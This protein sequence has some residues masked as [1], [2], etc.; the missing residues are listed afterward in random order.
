MIFSFILR[1]FVLHR[2]AKITTLPPHPTSP[3]PPRVLS[4]RLSITKDIFALDEQVIASFITKQ[5]EY[6]MYL[7]VFFTIFEVYLLQVEH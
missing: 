7:N 2:A 1:Y 5:K 3:H 4:D 6:N